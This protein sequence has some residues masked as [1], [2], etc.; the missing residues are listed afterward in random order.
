[1]I[2][3]TKNGV[4]GLLYFCFVKDLKVLLDFVVEQGESFVVDF[5]KTKILLDIKC[6]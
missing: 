4:F 1:M 2:L 5:I 6:S 3:L